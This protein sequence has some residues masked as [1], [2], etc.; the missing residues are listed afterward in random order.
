MQSCLHQ[1]KTFQGHQTVTALSTAC[2]ADRPSSTSNGSGCH[3][4]TTLLMPSLWSLDVIS[5]VGWLLLCFF[6]SSPASWS[7]LLVLWSHTSHQELVFTHHL[8]GHRNLLYNPSSPHR[9]PSEAT[10]IYLDISIFILSYLSHNLSFFI[11]LVQGFIAQWELFWV[12]FHTMYVSLVCLSLR[13]S[14]VSVQSKKA[15]TLF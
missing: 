1:D 12:W 11:P 15:L 6:L 7:L 14:L 13:C 3:F 8:R 2:S 4:P 10:E 5:V 9:S